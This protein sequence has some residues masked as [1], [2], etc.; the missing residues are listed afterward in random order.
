L[1][2]G[3]S[4]KR[5]NNKQTSFPL[6]PLFLCPFVLN[7][8]ESNVEKTAEIVNAVQPAGVTGAG[9]AGF[10]TYVKLQAQAE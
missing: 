8:Q 5:T 3:C 6:C 7:S 4:Y 10:P 2:V 9:G 1:I